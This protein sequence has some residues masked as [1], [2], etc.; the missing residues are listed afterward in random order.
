VDLADYGDFAECLS[1]PSFLPP[2]AACDCFDFDTSAT[3]DLFD[4]AQFQ[5]FFAP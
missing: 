5:V 4:L 1:G 2:G 3:V